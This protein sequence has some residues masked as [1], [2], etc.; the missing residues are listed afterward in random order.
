MFSNDS[1]EWK[2]KVRLIKVSGLFPFFKFNG[3]KSP[4]HFKCNDS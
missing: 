2:H 4:L 1:Q 3:F